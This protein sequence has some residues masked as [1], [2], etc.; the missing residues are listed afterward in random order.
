MVTILWRPSR[1]RQVPTPSSAIGHAEV[2]D[3]QPCR[4]WQ[5]RAALEEGRIE[6][7]A[8]PVGELK[9]LLDVRGRGMAQATSS[10]DYPAATGPA[11][12]AVQYGWPWGV[13]PWRANFG[14]TVAT[15]VLDG[16]PHAADD[17]R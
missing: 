16:H 2:G 9:V 14:R 12:L 11:A 17:A 10:R 15:H 6:Q 1:T 13:T 3:D 5:H 8:A 4:N 7:T